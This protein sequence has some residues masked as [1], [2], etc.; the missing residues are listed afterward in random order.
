M[1]KYAN[2][3]LKAVKIVREER[4]SPQE[5]W[6]KA[7]SLI[8]PNSKSSRDKTCPKNAFLGLCEE[9]LIEGVNPGSYTKSNKNKH[10]AI[11]AIQLLKHNKQMTEKQLWDS[12]EKDDIGKRHN[13]QMHVVKALFKN[14][15]VK[16]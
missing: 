8:F 6:S 12:I 15:Y 10:Y 5:A 9:G 11:Q 2:V 3:A 14:D 7:S 4:I 1:N 16:F 13:Q